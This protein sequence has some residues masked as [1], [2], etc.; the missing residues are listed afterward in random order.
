MVTAGRLQILDKQGSV[1]ADD[2][3]HFHVKR[4]IEASGRT[5]IAFLDPLLATEGTRRPVA[6]MIQEWF[7]GQ[8]GSLKAIASAV[9]VDKHWGAV[10]FGLGPLAGCWL[11]LGMLFRDSC[12]PLALLHSAVAKVV[13]VESFIVQVTHRN[14]APAEFCGIAAVRFP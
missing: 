4:M 10:L 3:V 13:G 1:M 7:D 11:R 12:T 14:F 2:E 5:D 9:W 8:R 6:K